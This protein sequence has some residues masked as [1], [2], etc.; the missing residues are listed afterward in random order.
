MTDRVKD[1]VVTQWLSLNHERISPTKVSVWLLPKTA[2]KKL[3]TQ[4]LTVNRTDG[5]CSMK[6]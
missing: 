3:V 5:K 4:S 1:Y 2:D 6:N